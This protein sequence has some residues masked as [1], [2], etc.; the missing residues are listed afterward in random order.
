MVAQNTQPSRNEITRSFREREAPRYTDSAERTT[1]SSM[2]PE[3]TLRV[4]NSPRDRFPAARTRVPPTANTA[5]P[6]GIFGVVAEIH[7]ETITVQCRIGNEDIEINLP[8]ALFAPEL[9]SYGQTVT[10]SLDHSGGYQRP[11]VQMR[12]PSPRD[13]LPGEAELDAW[14]DSL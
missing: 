14:V 7:A 2:V 9:Q 6:N 8:S 10:L 12:S 11:V 4:P 13:P 5:L 1:P 3:V